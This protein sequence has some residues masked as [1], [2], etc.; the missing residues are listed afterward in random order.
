MCLDRLE[1]AT[2]NL[3]RRVLSLSR[4]VKESSDSLDDDLTPG[5]SPI[6]HPVKSLVNLVVDTMARTCHGC[7]APLDEDHQDYPSG[8]QKCQLEHWDGC[9]GGIAVGKAPN[10]SEWTGC[11]LGYVFVE[12]I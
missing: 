8:W 10:G 2:Q 11:P 12:S 4:L 9:Q 3:G 5:P 7:H 6:S 1:A